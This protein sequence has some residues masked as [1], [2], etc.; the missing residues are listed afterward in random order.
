MFEWRDLIG[1]PFK[2]GGRDIDGLDCYGL[3]K[4]LMERQGINLPEFAYSTD[5]PSLLDLLI[6]GECKQLLIKLEKP[7]LG[8]IVVISIIEPYEHH[9]GVVVS[10]NEFLHVRKNTR[11]TLSRLDSPL[12]KGK[13]RG[14]YRVKV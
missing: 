14:F 1:I 10:R 4:I 12:W 7:E 11:V 13:I 6:R 3:V 8:A 9:L 5:E 2:S